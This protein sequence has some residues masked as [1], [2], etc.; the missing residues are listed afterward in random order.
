[1]RGARPLQCGRSANS[2]YCW[3]RAPA[4]SIEVL[5][6]SIQHAVDVLVSPRT[7]S[8]VSKPVD[9]AIRADDEEPASM[10][11]GHQKVA[12][13]PQKRQVN[14]GA[15]QTPTTRRRSPRA[16]AVPPDRCFPRARE[17]AGR[18]GGGDPEGRGALIALRRRS[19]GARR[20]PRSVHGAVGS[21]AAHPAWVAGRSFYALRGL[22][23]ENPLRLRPWQ[24]GPP[25]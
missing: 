1:M 23:A 13:P 25:P 6:N 10:I 21:F 3:Q 22:V 18:G 11:E 4:G 14:Q 8:C 19:S 17:R 12:V 20:S 9:L 7:V 5:A 15:A 24:E 16:R 2:T